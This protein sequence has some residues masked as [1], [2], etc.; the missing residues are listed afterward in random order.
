[1]IRAIGIV[2]GVTPQDRS[3]LYE[4]CDSDEPLVAAA[5]NGIVGYFWEN[6]GDLERALQAARRTLQAF[7]SREVPY[8]Q[9]VAHA[10]IAELCLQAERGDEARRHLLAVLLVLERLGTTAE[11]VGIQWWMVLANLQ[12]GDVDEAEHWLERT[13]PPRGDEPVGTRTYG[14]GVRAEIL[15]ARGEVE[16]GLRLWRRA[17]DLLRNAVDRSSAWRWTPARSRGPWR[18][19]PSP[20]SPTPSMAGSISWRS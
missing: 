11:V 13:A 14:L 16:T 12:L 15:L 10:R 9:A 19:R 7:E 1:M 5:A 20:W 6:E 2:L 18:S 3:A 8:L 17:V 4:L